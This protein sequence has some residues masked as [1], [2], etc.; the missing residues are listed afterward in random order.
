MPDLEIVG[1]A[2]R[3]GSG[4]WLTEVSD[5][6]LLC[7]YPTH[8]NQLKCDCCGNILEP[9]Q[10]SCRAFCL[11]E[12]TCLRTL[13]FNRNIMDCTGQNVSASSLKVRNRPLDINDLRLDNITLEVIEADFFDYVHLEYLYLNNSMVKVILPGAFERLPAIKILYLQDNEVAH[14]NGETF[15]NLSTLQEL[16]L[17]RNYISEIASETF[18][19]L[20]S[21][22]ILNLCDN[23]LKGISLDVFSVVSSL[24]RLTLYNN[25]FECDCTYGPEFK[26]FLSA[27]ANNIHRVQDITCFHDPQRNNRSEDLKL[28]HHFSKNEQRLTDISGYQN[29]SS[30]NYENISVIEEPVIKIDFSYCQEPQVHEVV[31]QEDVTFWLILVSVIFITIVIIC[32]AAYKNRFLIQV[33][34]YNKFGCF[35][36]HDDDNDVIKP[37]DVYV[38]CAEDDEEFM[39]EEIVPK[40]EEG[41]SSYKVMSPSQTT[42]A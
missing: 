37:Y 21:L 24:Q 16:Y 6:H 1:C 8:C 39:F 32:V 3:L 17:E 40:L 2:E 4:F 35:G 41:V 12:C 30:Q 23:R 29:I 31:S 13:D 22:K 20:S 34:M 15:G 27:N 14:L 9:E 7:S 10:C 26:Y 42:P 5:S 36:R 28:E 11:Q 19:Q 25:P 38:A 33:F 18:S